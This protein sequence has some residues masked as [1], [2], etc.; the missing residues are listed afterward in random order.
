MPRLI[1]NEPGFRGS[2]AERFER[3]FVPEPNSGCWIWTG[4]TDRRG[5]GQLRVTT[6]KNKTRLRYA[7]HV[8]LEIVGRKVPKGMEACHHCDV[9][10]CVNPD[11][12]FIGTHR[13]NV[14][15]S[16]SKGRASKPPSAK[17][18][19]GLK[20]YCHR[21]HLLDGGDVYWVNDGSRRMCNECRRI[22]KRLWRARTGN[23]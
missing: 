6:Q 3:K 17:K 18:G 2:V 22:N 9:P 11:H 20:T 8:S 1:F 12:L 7:T 10:A 16:W 5:Y 13:D 15:D 14:L 21:G 4:S 23:R 19:Q